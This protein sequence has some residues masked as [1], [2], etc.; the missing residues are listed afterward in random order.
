MFLLFL[1]ATCQVCTVSL[2]AGLYTYKGAAPDCLQRP[3]LRRSRFRQQVSASV[4][5]QMQILE[6]MHSK[7]RG[8]VM[9]PLASPR[10]DEEGW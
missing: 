6:E 7:E 3:L 5:L 4:M 1:T 8:V 2:K 9:T 10:N